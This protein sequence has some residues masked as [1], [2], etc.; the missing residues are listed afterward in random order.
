[1]P[2]RQV[3]VQWSLLLVVLL[4]LNLVLMEAVKVLLVLMVEQLYVMFLQKMLVV[5]QKMP[6]LLVVLVLAWSILVLPFFVA[7]FLVP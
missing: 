6:F 2:V 7:G 4:F 1:M 3:F 5:P